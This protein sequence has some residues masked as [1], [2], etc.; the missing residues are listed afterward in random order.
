MKTAAE[1]RKHAEECRV[2]AKQM[3][4]GEQRN[5]L[6]EMAKTWDHLARDREKLVRNHPEINNSKKPAKA[7]LPAK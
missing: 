3:S 4:E 5:Q 2:L 1:Y 6:L 7:Q